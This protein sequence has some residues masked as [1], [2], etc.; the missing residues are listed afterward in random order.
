[1]GNWLSK[2]K[3]LTYAELLENQ[4]KIIADILYSKAHEV[5]GFEDPH[6][7][8]VQFFLS[9]KAP[10]AGARHNPL[11]GPMQKAMEPHVEL[12]AEEYVNAIGKNNKSGC[13]RASFGCTFEIPYTS[14]YSY[15]KPLTNESWENS[16]RK[17]RLIFRLFAEPSDYVH[18]KKGK[19]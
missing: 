7:M 1:M 8:F 16:T 14:E 6:K 18:N 2:A 17:L 12:L 3:D 10:K 11:T 4:A 15:L 5:L 13:W 19:E 9:P